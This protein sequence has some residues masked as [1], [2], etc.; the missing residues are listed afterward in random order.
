MWLRLY[1]H[2]TGDL[3]VEVAHVRMELEAYKEPWVYAYGKVSPT[4]DKDRAL[5]LGLKPSSL[6]C[7]KPPC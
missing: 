5:A 3:Q 2:A 1:L 4:K 7:L 6:N